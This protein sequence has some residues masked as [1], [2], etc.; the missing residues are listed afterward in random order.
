MKSIRGK[1]GVF[2]FFLDLCVDHDKGGCELNL[3][4]DFLVDGLC[5]Y[6]PG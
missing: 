2:F 1:Q 6:K 3:V 5:A 4:N